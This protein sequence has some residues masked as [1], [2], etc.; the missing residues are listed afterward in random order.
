ML[1]SMLGAVLLLLPI[2]FMAWYWSIIHCVVLE[3]RLTWALITK[4][5]CAPQCWWVRE[6]SG[7][8]KKNDIKSQKRNETN[9]R[10]KL[11]C[12]LG[13]IQCLKDKSIM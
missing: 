11:W 10:R 13:W 8:G 7:V 2:Q 12:D 6:V 5:S 9:C 4:L 3:E 1:L